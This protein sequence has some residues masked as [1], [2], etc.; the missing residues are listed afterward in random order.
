MKPAHYSKVEKARLTKLFMGK[1]PQVH[2]V[3]N[4]AA[5]PNKRE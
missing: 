3:K 2:N 5:N 4:G 1:Y